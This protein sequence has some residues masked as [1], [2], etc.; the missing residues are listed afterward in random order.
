MTPRT[1]TPAEAIEIVASRDELLVPL[2]P[3]QPV[4]FLHALADRD[5]YVNLEIGGALLVDIFEVL[6]KPGVRF[7]SGFFGPAERFLADAGHAI[8]FVPAGFRQFGRIAEQI[9]ARVVATAAAPP[10]ADGMLSLSLHAGATVEEIHRAGSDPDR[11]LIVEAN[12]RLPRTFGLPPEHTHAVHL[13]EVDVVVESEREPIII[14]DP[15]P[16][17]VEVAIAEHVARF[18]R[19]G[20][21]LQTGIGAIP[22]AVVRLLATEEAGDYGVHSEMFTTGLMHL[23][24]AGKVTN[25]RKGI[26][27]GYSVSTFS[28]GT[29]ELYD[30]LDGNDAVRFLPVAD[31]NDPDI[32]A[33]NRNMVTINGALAVDLLGQV[34][35]DTIG[36]RQFSGIGG[37]EDFVSGG[38][39]GLDDRS[40]VCLP[41]VTRLGET[42]VSRI[43]ATLPPGTA[44]TT[45]RHVVDVVVT[46]HGAAELAGR[47]VAERAEALVEVAAPF[48]RDELRAAAAKLSGS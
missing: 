6:T 23:H 28:A 11:V 21:T 8:E 4:S 12:P 30:W 22:S 43:V 35:A 33:S 19:D 13:D 16:G 34:T 17:A 42:E 18:V 9:G 38:S 46:E 2:G 45:P 24:K 25:R 32:I 7:R 26:H 14:E 29:R 41:S 48:A 31:V 40:I 27:E 44:V 47:T 5:D 15:E 39:I 3:G 1:L 10:D 37:H 20:S 36:S